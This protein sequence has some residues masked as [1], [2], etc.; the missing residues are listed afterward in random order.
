MGLAAVL[1]ICFSAGASADNLANALPKG[2][3]ETPRPDYDAQGIALDNWT[4]FPS[5]AATANYDDNVFRSLANRNWDWYF[6]TTPAFRLQR[7]TQDGVFDIFGDADFFNYVEFPRLNLTDWTIGADSKLNLSTH[8][9]AAL[10]GYYGEY[11]ED[12]ASV[13][14]I[15]NPS[16][17]REYTRYFKGHFETAASYGSGDW[18]V[19]GGASLDRFDW[20]STVLLSGLHVSNEDRN[21]TYVDPYARVAYQVA[22]SY[23][24][25]AR[26][27]YDR[28]D[29]DELRD[30]FGFDRDSSGVEL[31]G[32][33]TALI[34]QTLNLDAFL[35]YREQQFRNFA[36]DPDHRLQDVAELDYGLTADWYAAPTFTA[37]LSATRSLSDLILP[38]ASLSDDQTVRL[39]ADWEARHD[40][41]VQE[42]VAYTYSRLIGTERVDR[43]PAAGVTLRYL[44]NRYASA[45]LAYLFTARHSTDRPSEFSDQIVTVGLNLHI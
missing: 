41:I 28:R 17:E 23:Q 39:S 8:F 14:L 22:P 19:S 27:L 13:N 45:E 11:H 16:A 42:F 15:E 44:I 26:A 43:Y 21:A 33:M 36:V 37:H 32:G 40:V 3:M 6:E 34:G 1:T 9:A 12:F 38:D 4:L 10:S 35:G 30:R 25:Y 2:V 18:L 24:V 20:Q 29:F 5:L 7:K 31:D